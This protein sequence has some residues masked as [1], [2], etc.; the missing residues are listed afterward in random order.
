MINIFNQ[1]EEIIIT[2]VGGEELIKI[3]GV[4]III[5]IAYYARKMVITQKIVS[6]NAK[7]VHD[8]LT[9]KKTVISGKNKKLIS[10]KIMTLM[11]NCSTHV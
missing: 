8:T 3:K 4:E 9:L 2:V 5:H 11:I 1:I 10:Q 6:T 7:N